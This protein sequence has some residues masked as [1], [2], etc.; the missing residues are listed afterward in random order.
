M[1]REDFMTAYEKRLYKGVQK[2]QADLLKDTKLL[3]NTVR[4]CLGITVPKELDDGSI[5]EV[6]IAAE[7]VTKKVKY[8]MEH[9]EKIDLKELASVLNESKVEVNAN[10]KGAKE[11]FEDIT[12]K[13]DET[14]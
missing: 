11:L 10:V 14:K 7:L 3:E 5:V 4:N 6:P 8:L 2:T 1:P 13:K 9:P 12:I